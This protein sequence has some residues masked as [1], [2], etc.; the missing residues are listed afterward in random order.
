MLWWIVAALVVVPLLL[1]AA[2]A[3]SLADHVAELQRVR[4]LAEERI[5]GQA[6]R[7]AARVADLRGRLAH[8]SAGT[9]ARRRPATAPSTGSGKPAKHT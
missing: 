3:V 4:A 2:A 9:P 5:R 1:L 8:V 7:L 6:A